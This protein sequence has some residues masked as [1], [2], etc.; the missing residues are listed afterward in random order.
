[1]GA[2]G[3]VLPEASQETG[4]WVAVGLSNL[5]TR[6]NQT[7]RPYCLKINDGIIVSFSHAIHSLIQHIFIWPCMSGSMLTT[8]H[9][10]V[11]KTSLC[12][13]GILKCYF[14]EVSP[15][16]CPWGHDIWAELWAVR[17]SLPWK[18]TEGKMFYSGKSKCK[19]PGVER[20]LAYSMG[21]LAVMKWE[22]SSCGPSQVMSRIA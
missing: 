18:A 21:E 10:A 20:S 19:D 6:P 9:S 5:L 3:L 11:D 13:H 4:R 14:I 8:G 2:F 12:V 15:R 17:R 7:L 22:N 16:R 1:M